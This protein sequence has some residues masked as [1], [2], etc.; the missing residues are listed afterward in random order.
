MIKHFMEHSQLNMNM[1]KKKS[2]TRYCL[3]GCCLLV[4]LKCHKVAFCIEVW[5]ELFG[6]LNC[7]LYF[8]KEN[9]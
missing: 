6:N 7:K 1:C 3:S 8:K 5:L 9:Y 4:T 2:S